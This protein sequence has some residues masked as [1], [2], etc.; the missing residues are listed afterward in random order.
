MGKNCRGRSA[1]TTK[2]GTGAASVKSSIAVLSL[3]LHITAGRHPRIGGP[4]LD[5][6]SRIPT[7]TPKRGPGQWD[8]SLSGATLYAPSG[9][10]RS[11]ASCEGS[12]VTICSAFIG[13]CRAECYPATY[14]QLS[15]VQLAPV[16]ATAARVS[17]P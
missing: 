4:A 11:A 7:F 5:Q 13:S 17:F 2:P 6:G 1:G 9:L 8:P 3:S 14:Q 16:P 10:S 12:F 15:A